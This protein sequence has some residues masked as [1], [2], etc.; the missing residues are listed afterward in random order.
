MPSGLVEAFA[1]PA[2]RAADDG[3]GRMLKRPR[4][5]WS[6]RANTPGHS[7]GLY[8]RDVC[9]AW[10]ER[11]DM[12]QERSDFNASQWV[13]AQ[14]RRYFRMDR[15]T[16]N[17]FLTAY[18]YLFPGDDSTCRWRPVVGTYKRVCVLLNWL[19]TGISYAQLGAVFDLSR[20]EVCKIVHEGVDVLWKVLVKDEVRFPET[21][22]ELLET[23]RGFYGLCSLPALDGT[24]VK[25]NKPGKDIVRFSDV[26]FCYKKYCAIIVLAA[27]D[28]LGLFTYVSAG[29]P[30]SAGDAS[31]WNHCDLK[32]D[33]DAEKLLVLDEPELRQLHQWAGFQLKRPYIVADTA[34]ALSPTL[35]KCYDV[36]NPTQPQFNFNYSVI[37]TRRVVECAFGRLKA[38]WQILKDNKL[39][40]PKFAS[41]IATVCCALHNFIERGVTRLD[42]QLFMVPQDLPEFVPSDNVSVDRRRERNVGA[43]TLRDNLATTAAAEPLRAVTRNEVPAP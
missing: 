10:E 18:A 31:T 21:S 25:I 42:N 27:V 16:F 23:C 30:G 5:L 14:Y 34:F 13:D 11:L 20:A 39:S 9:G 40:D 1:A 26:Y 41:K 37:R 7:F 35:M 36:A 4:T 28:S 22:L 33:I 12:A 17:R 32:E 43:L 38:R 29:A 2:R 24:F 15:A 19:A 8:E 3:E 6:S